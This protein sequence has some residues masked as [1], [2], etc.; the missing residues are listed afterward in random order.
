MYW[1][2]LYCL[3][4]INSVWAT[5]VAMHINFFFCY[6]ENQLLG[7]V[8]RKGYFIPVYNNYLFLWGKFLYVAFDRNTSFFCCPIHK[9]LVELFS[10]LIFSFFCKSKDDCDE[11]IDLKSTLPEQ[12]ASGRIESIW[13]AIS[14]HPFQNKW[15]HCFECWFLLHLWCWTSIIFWSMYLGKMVGNMFNDSIPCV[16][17]A[18]SLHVVPPSCYY[19]C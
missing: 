5:L 14:M 2:Q 13:I 19:C 16:W 6:K 8:I 4:K 1:Y 12:L 10:N 15:I 3:N 17:K 9:L 11:V 18:G 7:H